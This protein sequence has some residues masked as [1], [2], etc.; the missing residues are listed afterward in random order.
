M[1]AE[2]PGVRVITL[3]RPGKANALSAELVE[4]LLAQLE[5]HAAEDMRNVVSSAS[6][7]GLKERI[8]KYLAR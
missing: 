2:R 7:P 1:A 6:V 5:A 3:A 8:A 4:S